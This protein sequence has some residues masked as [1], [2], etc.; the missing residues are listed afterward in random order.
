MKWFHVIGLSS[1]AVLALAAGDAPSPRLTAVQTVYIMPMGGGMDQY[2][3]NRLTAMHVVQVAADPENADAIFTD[4]LGENFERRL[5][6]LYPKPAPPKADDDKDKDKDK[7]EKS[8]VRDAVALADKGQATAPVSTFGR[9]KGNFFLVDRKT[10]NVL[11]STYE[12]PTG[13]RPEQLK[14]T[15]DII[16]KQF[17]T[18][19][20]GK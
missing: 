10:R 8:S 5:E 12:K 6:D 1:V 20:T 2:L 7:A 11:W 3:A 19:R 14:H 13:T 4:R 17:R 9:G 15:A 16:A 18:A